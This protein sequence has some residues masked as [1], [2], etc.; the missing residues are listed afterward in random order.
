MNRK[1]ALTTVLCTLLLAVPKLRAEAPVSSASTAPEVDPLVKASAYGDKSV[2]SYSGSDPLPWT[3]FHPKDF[4]SAKIGFDSNGVTPVGTVPAPGIHPRIFFSPGDL[5]TVRK[6]IKEDPGAQAAWKLVLA[7]SHALNLTYDEKADYAQPDW[8]NGSFHVHGRTDQV[9]RIGGYG[10][11]REDYYGLLAAG[12]PTETFENPKNG[13]KSRPSGFF[14][15]AAI[16]AFRCLIDDDAAGAKKLAAAV[17]TSVKFEQERRAKEDKPVKPGQPPH[18]STPRYDASQL[19]LVYDFIYNWMTPDQK[20][21]IHDELVLLSSFVDGYG[22][23]SHAET[24]RSNWAT[25]SYQVWDTVAIEGE[26]GFND[27]K[28]LGLYR[29]WRGFFTYSFFNSGCAYEAEGKLLFGLDA[30]VAFDRIAPKYGLPL[31]S[32]HPLIR[33]HYGKFTALSVM[34]TQDNRYAIFDILGGMGQ[35]LCTPQDLVV[36]HYL[37]PGDKTID[38]I[39]RGMVGEDFRRLPMPSHSWNNLITDAIFATTHHPENTPEKIGLPLTFFC[40]QRALMMTRSSWD[41]NAT[42]LT[43]HVRGASGGHPYADR[44]GIM[45]AAQGRAWVTIPFKDGKSWQCSTVTFN[46]CEQ[47]STTPGRVVDF[48]DEPGATF[49]VGDSKYCWDWVWGGSDKNKQGQAVTR[50][51]VDDENIELGKTRKPVELS[52]NDF[53]YTKVDVI[54][55]TQPMKYSGHWLAPDGTLRSYF[56]MVNNP[57]IKS[58]RTTGLVRG[59]HPYVLVLDDIQH[60]ALP[61]LY[62]WHLSLPADL[63]KVEKQT[64]GA[65][66][67]DLF[68]AAK[69]SLDGKGAPI[70][71][72]PL[73]LVR[74]LDQK[75]SPEQP[76]IIE[77]NPRV[78][79]LGTRAVAPAFKVLIHALRAG[80]PVPQTTPLRDGRIE[81]GF[82]DQKDVL[83]F[84][85]SASGKT[86]LVITRDGKDIIAIR[87]PVPKLNDH[88]SDLLTSRQVA[89]AA[90]AT[91]L[92]TFNP[93]DIPGL[94]AGWNFSTPAPDGYPAMQT[95]VAPIPSTNTWTLPGL[96]GTALGVSNKGVTVPFAFKDQCPKELTLSFWVKWLKT[97]PASASEKTSDGPW[98]GSVISVNGGNGFSLNLVQGGLNFQSA[99]SSDLLPSAALFGWTH[100]TVTTDGRSETLYVNGQPQLTYILAKPLNLGNRIDLAGGGYGG[101]SGAYQDLRIYNRALSAEEILKMALKATTPGSP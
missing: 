58:F 57:V 48:V 29:G 64:D 32:Q 94:V 62:E 98:M 65:Q 75:G 69:E 36:A 70:A 59:A 23:F 53:A 20:K 83:K 96:S 84:S 1:I 93:A 9:M 4:G 34:P 90:V 13:G 49:M 85:E 74:V 100:Y 54:D 51:D 89:T 22:T 15:A 2:W 26:P 46:G 45:L 55:Y 77:A 6:R 18:P 66:P 92:S 80:D 14:F 76:R 7:Y 67:G 40:G 38:F 37:F 86:D 88:D 24:S 42:F 56:K 82:P 3:M 52:F 30:V 81:V 28:F 8:A 33:N 16:E 91:N 95:N 101:F 5:P 44:N 99:G 72:A 97:P 63:I 78:L 68:L 43:M 27:L 60:D 17:E 10:T 47:S 73:L 11:N 31:L 25:F 12:K 21:L 79:T 71:G 35:G 19:G 61:A 41:T 50:K 87:N 39:Y